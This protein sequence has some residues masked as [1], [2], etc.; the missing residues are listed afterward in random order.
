M[1]SLVPEYQMF[2]HVRERTG[3]ALPGIAPSNTYQ[4]ADGLY[5][6][7]AGNGDAIFKRLMR[8]IGRDDLGEDPAL[9]HNEGRVQHIEILDAA[10]SAFT[11]RHSQGQVLDALEEAAVP[12]GRVYT[13]ADIMVDPHYHARNMIEHHHLPRG[14]PIDLPGIVPKLS[15]T[16][17]RTQWL[18]PPLG[19]HTEEVLASIGIEREEFDR[20][21]SSGVI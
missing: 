20:L 3:A 10:I 4:C 6:A 19:A 15:A 14:E 1:E 2:G 17:G 8:A 21:R 9:A 13:V 7:I 12:S 16:P 11:L 5:V 18:G